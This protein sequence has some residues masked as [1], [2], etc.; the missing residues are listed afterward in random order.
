MDHAGSNWGGGEGCVRFPIYL[1]IDDSPE[2][3]IQ[4]MKP[5]KKK[6]DPK[7]FGLSREKR[8]LE[9]G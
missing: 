7:D 4:S 3:W 5:E 6:K 1:K 8:A 2:V 9:E